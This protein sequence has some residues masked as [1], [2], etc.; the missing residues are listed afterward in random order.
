MYGSFTEHRT[1]TQVRPEHRTHTVT[2]ATHSRF[3]TLWISCTLFV[4]TLGLYHLNG[5]ALPGGDT[6][7]HRYL[8]LS[9]ICSGDL[10]FDEFPLGR[11]RR[12]R[13]MEQ[14]YFLVPGRDRHQHSSFGVGPGLMA[15]PV[16]AV[17]RLCHNIFTY[18]SILQL[19]KW[20][21]SL[22][23][24]LSV[25]LLFL[26][27][28]TEIGYGGAFVIALAWGW[29]TSS[30]S[31]ISQS[32]WQHTGAAPWLLGALLCLVYGRKRN[33][34]EQAA[35]LSHKQAASLSHK[36]ATSLPHKQATSLSC[37]QAPSSPHERWIPWAGLCLGFATVCRTTNALIA[38]TFTLY[39]FLYHRR[40]L[41]RFLMLA[42]IPAILLFAY[43]THAFGSPFKF[44]QLLIGPALA[45]WKTGVASNVVTHP[46]I[47]LQGLAGTL[48][49][50][51]RGI[52]VYSP[53]LWFGLVGLL[54]SWRKGGDPLYRWASI[55]FTAVILLHGVWYDW[56]GGWT[57]GYRRPFD[58][59]FLLAFGICPLWE[60][61]KTTRWKRWTFAA[62]L[63]CSISI[64][65]MGAFSYDITSWNGKPDVD[66]NPHR[67]WSVTQSQLAFYLKNP[68]WVRK[69]KLQDSPRWTITVCPVRAYPPGIS[70]RR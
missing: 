13:T 49:S 64:Q 55:A 70:P 9:V 57:F 2:M 62:L 53:V 52:F 44:G 61:I 16:F 54:L 28:L 1:R 4:L 43:N 26:A 39:V 63:F 17:A 23:M 50:P 7:P 29:G 34:D 35:S 47:A 65:G 42:A 60:S 33:D 3:R 21:A 51:S 8:P 38:L 68:R 48:F 15:V 20:A 66:R 19:G 18:D 5:K 6:V 59:V 10:N 30:W 69:I 24:A 67:L 22:M 27:C 46:L 31:M 11:I 12:N 32:L 14:P 37:E 25:L 56:W 36:Q 41:W 45:K 40:M 58:A